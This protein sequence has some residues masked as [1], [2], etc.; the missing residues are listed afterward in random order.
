M[1]LGLLAGCTTLGPMPATTGV[2]A[3]PASATGLD[4]QAGVVPGFYL[5][6]AAQQST[7]GAAIPQL[8]ALFDFGALW[9]GL[10]VG[11]RAYGRSGDAIGE[12]F[13]GYRTTLDDGISIAGVVYGTANRAGDRGASYDATR[14]GAEVMVDAR[15][16]QPAK[17]VAVH[18]QL[19]GSMTRIAAHGTYC[20]SAG[21]GVDC[22]DTGGSDPGDLTASAHVSGVY[23]AGTAKL[24]IELERD[25]RRAFHGAELAVLV[26]VG[27]MPK[28]Q[29]GVQ[30]DAAFYASVGLLVT[31]GFGDTREPRR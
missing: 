24:A 26:G 4:V 23:P 20:T 1:L 5:S 18:G 31:I 13:V 22:S 15:L 29:D 6:N 2:S 27:A 3:I 16:A 25:S 9:P 12:P 21:Y 8:S 7:D 19:S 14:A 30:I 17:R 10:I 28:V 11:A